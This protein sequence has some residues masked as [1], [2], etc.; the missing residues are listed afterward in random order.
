MDIGINEELD[1]LAAT[2]SA[3]VSLD[4]TTGRILGYSVQT[5]DADAARIAA[6][7]TRQVPQ[8][9][10]AWQERRGIIRVTAPLHLPSDPETGMVPRLFVPVRHDDQ[11][12][13]LLWVLETT[14]V[15]GPSEVAAAVRTARRLA[16][17][18]APAVRP[19]PRRASPSELLRKLSRSVD[20]EPE[21]AEELAAG[22]RSVVTVALPVAPEGDRPG[23]W[24]AST[25]S[26]LER[27]LA[28]LVR[29]RRVC[30]AAYVERDHLALLHV[31]GGHGLL[32]ELRRRLGPTASTNPVVT[33][34]AEGSSPREALDRARAAAQWTALDPALPR[35]TTW[36]QLGLHDQASRLPPDTPGARGALDPLLEH[37]ASGAM[38]LATV[39]TYLDLA[40]DAQRTAAALG[41]HRTTLYYRLTRAEHLLGLD[42]SDGMVRTRLHLELKRRRVHRRGTGPVLPRSLAEIPTE[43]GG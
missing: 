19:H 40:A 23:A 11:T 14:R 20:L 2:V 31:D 12:L 8:A 9:V 15:L 39:E 4:D 41:L 16:L 30:T 10:R 26:D 42:L 22:G 38:L 6:I 35:D 21:E 3:S 34:T 43:E 17:R 25:T 13:G 36:A 7:L 33:G 5:D 37:E 24:S 27:A 18:L 1:L 29:T 28:G 32:D